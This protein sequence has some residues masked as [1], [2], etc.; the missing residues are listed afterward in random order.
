MKADAEK[1]TKLKAGA[2]RTKELKPA[3]GKITKLMTE[4]RDMSK[5]KAR[6]KRTMERKEEGGEGKKW[7]TG[8]REK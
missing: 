6:A 5:L 4:A 1:M 2:K 8:G 3:A 7:K